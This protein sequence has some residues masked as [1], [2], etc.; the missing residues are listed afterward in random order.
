VKK[1]TRVAAALLERVAR[2]AEG[3]R[4]LGPRGLVVLGYHRIDDSGGGLSV[5]ADHFRAHLDW[6]QTEG[7]RVVPLDDR[8]VLEGAARPRVAFTFDDGYASVAESAWPEL[9]ARGWPAIVYA[10]PAYVEGNLR[11]P[12]DVASDERSA[13]LMDA[14]LLRQL[15]DDGMA[16][17]S[18]SVTHRYLPGL[19]TREAH[20]EIRESRR[21]LEDLLG[22]GV[23]SFSY[24]MGG[25]NRRLRGFV[26][27]AGYRTA[28]TVLRGRNGPGRDPLT[29]RRPVVESDPDDFA[30][31]LKG[32]F[33]F[34]RPLDWGRE[35][36]HQWSAPRHRSSAPD[37]VRT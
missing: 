20:A 24:P 33:D 9:K 18:H 23:T 19:A 25:W 14:S 4:L 10:V 27:G 29:L 13:R 21:M 15:A 28:V 30:R 2:P 32:Y 36:W 3:T 16:V 12:W 26:A 5:R 31:I 22:R 7:L 1:T 34:L 17:G 11:F 35:R 6:I 37:R 8:A